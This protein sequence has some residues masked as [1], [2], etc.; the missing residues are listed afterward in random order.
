VNFDWST[1]R[2]TGRVAVGQPNPAGGNLDALAVAKI[3][4]YQVDNNVRWNPALITFEKG[5][6]DAATDENDL[7]TVIIPTIKKR[8]QFVTEFRR[9]GGNATSVSFDDLITQWYP[10]SHS[11]NNNHHISGTQAGQAYNNG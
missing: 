5:R 7:K 9:V 11:V 6:I 1:N 3:D 10:S 4:A 8:R 2:R